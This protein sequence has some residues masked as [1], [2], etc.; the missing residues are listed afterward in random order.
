VSFAGIMDEDRENKLKL[1]NILWKSNYVCRLEVALKD[2]SLRGMEYIKKAKQVLKRPWTDIDVLAWRY[3][4]F[5][6]INIITASIKGEAKQTKDKAEIFKLAGIN[7]ILKPVTSYYVKN[8]PSI[9]ELFL[10]ASNLNIS[11]I[12]KSALNDMLNRCLLK[13]F[14]NEIKKDLIL[15]ETGANLIGEALNFFKDTNPELYDFITS[16][17]W[18]TKFPIKYYLAEQC[19]IKTSEFV[20]KDDQKSI[21]L[22]LYSFSN[23]L[24]VIAELISKLDCCRFTDLDL[25][26]IKTMEMDASGAD[27]ARNV[28]TAFIE[29]LKKVKSVVEIQAISNEAYSPERFFPHY[30][31]Y[32]DILKEC[33]KKNTAL[34]TAIRIIDFLLFNFVEKGDFFD[35]EKLPSD[36]FPELQ[37][38]KEALYLIRFILLNFFNKMKLRLLHTFGKLFNILR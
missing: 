27:L 34:F 14:D 4:P 24:I 8:N 31:R 10:F 17:M 3:D 25:F 32:S 11:I 15:T 19:F 30:K 13:Y 16:D 37:L 20:N 33:W 12:S 29:G 7:Q 9:E 23:Y 36:Y 1:F 26:L 18:N 2:Y 6:S 28:Y 21:I 35:A 22:L 38:N 5:S